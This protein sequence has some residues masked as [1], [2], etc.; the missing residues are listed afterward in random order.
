MP[1]E[2]KIDE[3]DAILQVRVHGAMSFDEMCA[4]RSDAANMLQEKHLQ[5]LL[6]DLRDYLTSLGIGT[7]QRYEFGAS[8][9]EAGIP[10]ATRIAHVLPKDPTNVANLR[11]I[12]T[13]AFNRGVMVR[14]FDDIDAA[15]SWL[16]ESKI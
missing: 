15:R 10:S 2:L 7:L 13:V 14:E 1:Y 4:S 11:F 6:I 3:A 8:Y 16:L 9:R 12:A 5:R